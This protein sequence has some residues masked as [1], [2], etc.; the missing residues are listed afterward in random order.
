MLQIPISTGGGNHIAET[1]NVGGTGL[2]IRLLWNER[3]GHWFADFE[4]SLGKNFGIRII[5]ESPL[6][7]SSNRVLPEGD[8]VLLRNEASGTE[9]PGYSNLGT[10]WGLYYVDGEDAEM[11]HS[12]GVI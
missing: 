5:P 3:D 6:L 2:A 12:Y 8:L 11:L 4:S 1:V 7:K 9:Q 10:E